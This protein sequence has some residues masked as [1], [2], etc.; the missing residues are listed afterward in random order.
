MA[1]GS[2]VQHLTLRPWGAAGVTRYLA[3]NNE[4]VH[5]EL[6]LTF[7]IMSGEYGGVVGKRK[8]LFVYRFI[9]CL[10]TAWKY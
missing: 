3:H 8:D 6:L 1:H 7:I 5:T 2:T 10:W 9:E 4:N